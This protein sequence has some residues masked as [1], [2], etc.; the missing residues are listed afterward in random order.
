MVKIDRALLESFPLLLP[1]LVEQRRIAE[2]LSAVDEVI[3]KAAVVVQQL[4][5]ARR[6]LLR[7]LLA[8][9][10]PSRRH[11]CRQ[12]EVGPAPESWTETTLGEL[13]SDVTY[14]TSVKCDGDSSALPVLRIPNVV[15]G[16][17]TTDLKYA[18]LRDA[19]VEQLR[20]SDGDLL[21]V[22]TNGNPDYVGRSIV[23]PRMPGTWLFASYL[24]RVRVSR[25]KVDPRF[26]HI[27]LQEPGV[28]RTMEKAIRTS[29]GN[30]N[31]NSVG[32][33]ATRLNLPS[34]PEQMEIA[35]GIE[36]LDARLRREI[37]YSL[38]L[39]SLKSS[40]AEAVLSGQLRVDPHANHGPEQKL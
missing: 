37:K 33:R 9:G 30:Y 13:A 27:A 3:G 16:Q 4:V 25:A 19:D 24:I 18:R 12:T 1:P 17:L 35:D 15:S 21:F 36:A 26:V 20:L 28:R 5:I 34:L 31:L 23:F 22:R 39:R 6:S 8:S 14:G 10:M 32:I 7:R 11:R 38:G 29:A 2:A 40:L